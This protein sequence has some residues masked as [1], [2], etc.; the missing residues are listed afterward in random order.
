MASAQKIVACCSTVY[1]LCG[2]RTHGICLY[3]VQVYAVISLLARLVS[4][5]CAVVFADLLMVT[6]T[7]A[8]AGL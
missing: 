1:A 5:V 2:S 8:Y 3:S 6:E 7:K 4:V